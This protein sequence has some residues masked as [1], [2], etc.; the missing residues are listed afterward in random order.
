LYKAVNGFKWPTLQVAELLSPYV[1]TPRRRSFWLFGVDV[2]SQPR[3][4]AFTLRDRGMVYQPNQV[5]GNKP[6]TVG[7]QYS[8]VALLPETESGNRCGCCLPC[9]SWLC[10]WG[11]IPFSKWGHASRRVAF[12]DAKSQWRK[13]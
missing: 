8:T 6:V 13:D 3:A 10:K 9:M 1:P 5:M 7:H 11:S 12:F 2:T 4:Y